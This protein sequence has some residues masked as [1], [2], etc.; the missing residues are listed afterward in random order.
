VTSYLPPRYL[1]GLV[2]LLVA[3]VV[4]VVDPLSVLVLLVTGP[5]LVLFLVLIGRRAKELADRRFRDL[6]L[7]SSSFLDLLQGLPT[8]KMFGRS[9]EQVANVQAVSRQYGTATM[10]VLRTAFETAFVLELS[11]TIAT[12]LVAVEVGLR[13]V[14][15][16]IGFEAAL[17]VLIVTPEFFLPIRQ[18]SLRYHAGATGQTAATAIFELLDTP[19]PA[20]VEPAPPPRIFASD[21]PGIHF[22]HVHFAYGTERTALHDVSFDLPHGSQTALI[23]ATG[24]GKTTIAN[25]LLRFIEPQG[26]LLAVEGVPL[27]EIDETAWRTRV[28]WVPQRPYLF[29]GTVADNIRLAKPDATWQE[30]AEAARA[31]GAHAFIQDLPQGYDTALGEDGTRLSGGEQQ[32]LAIA[33]SFLK[34]APYLILD[35]PTSHLDA[36]NEAAISSALE[37][38]ARG[39]TVLIIAHRLRLVENADQVLVLDH[40]R[41]VDSGSPEDVLPRHRDFSRQASRAVRTR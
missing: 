16:S 3:L 9:K 39:R 4:L 18:L 31:A 25:L 23:G 38:L 24:A 35:E 12:A 27:S 41:I 20:R 15:G 11:A 10:S 22:E 32:R 5:L 26:G 7:L 1:A 37:S 13:L 40:G 36:T 8:L 17:A 6:G 21:S 19:V 33:R 2:P 28:A 29:Y 34:D 30:I 14:H